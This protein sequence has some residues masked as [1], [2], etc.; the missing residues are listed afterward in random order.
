MEA[1][2]G[3]VGRMWRRWGG[4]V[5]RQWTKEDVEEGNIGEDVERGGD[6]G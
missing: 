3:G 2:G 4:G 1:G 6:S 5:R